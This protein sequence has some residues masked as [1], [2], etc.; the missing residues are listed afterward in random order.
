M[1]FELGHEFH[2]DGE[3]AWLGG[4][5]FGHELS[6]RLEGMAELHAE[7]TESLARSAVAVN[8][9]A[10]VVAGTHGTLLMSLGRDLHNHLEDEATIFGYV[11]WQLTF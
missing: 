1:N 5:V 3:D 11:G 8:V 4:I 6:D 2:S 9:G 10:R 7:S